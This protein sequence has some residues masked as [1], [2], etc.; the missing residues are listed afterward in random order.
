MNLY[1]IYIYIV[2]KWNVSA[3]MLGTK[4]ASTNFQIV[5]VSIRLF[6]H[7]AIRLE[8]IN[9]KTKSNPIL[10]KLKHTFGLPVK[11]VE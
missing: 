3:Y 7:N 8:I 9:K 10:L 4:L 11:K 6:D 5:L 1:S 2:H